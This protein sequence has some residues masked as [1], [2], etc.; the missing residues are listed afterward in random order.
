MYP[1]TKCMP[2]DVYPLFVK[3]PVISLITE[4]RPLILNT[5]PYYF[6]VWLDYTNPY[7][8][9]PGKYF[10]KYCDYKVPNDC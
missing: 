2:T 10:H 8:S 4:S 3:L 5:K 6:Q 9:G 1:P 7:S